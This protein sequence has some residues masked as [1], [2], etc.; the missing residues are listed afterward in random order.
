M[1]IKANTTLGSKTKI[2]N[3]VDGKIYLK[4]VQYN[5]KTKKAIIYVTDNFN[6][7]LVTKNIFGKIKIATKKVY[8]RG[9]KAI[10]KQTG[11]EIK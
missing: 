11:E 1:I 5:T 7:V 9:T 10:N 8:L 3:I 4:V 2:I 6:K